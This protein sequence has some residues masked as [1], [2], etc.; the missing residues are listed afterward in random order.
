MWSAGLILYI[1]LSGR[2]PFDK[3]GTATDKQVTAFVTV[4][5]VIVNT[6]TF[7]D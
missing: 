4:D 2:H 1:M 5:T 6:V 3:D 7:N